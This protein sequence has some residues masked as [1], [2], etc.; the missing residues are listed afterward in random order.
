MNSILN[1]IFRAIHEGK[2]L[3]IEYQN[4]DNQVTK[5]WIGIRSMNIQNRTLTVDG[6]HLGQLTVKSLDWVRI[7]GI[8]SSQIVEGSYYPVNKRLVDDI[9]MN[10][11]KYRSIFRSSQ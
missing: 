5:Y 10:P 4:R 2:W 9:Y 1:D 11:E 8:L 7:D 3:H 6:L